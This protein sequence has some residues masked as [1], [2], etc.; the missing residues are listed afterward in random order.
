MEISIKGKHVDIGESLQS[1]AEDN[2]IT[3]VKKY[4]DNALDAKVIFSRESHLFLVDISVHVGRGMLVQGS[5]SLEDPYAAFDSALARISKQLRRYK[6]RLRSHRGSDKTQL[7][8]YSIIAPESE[9]EEVPEDAQPT[10]VAEMSHEISNLTVSEAVM[11]MDL[12]NAPVMM[13]RNSAHG[14]LNVVY[15]RNDGNVGWID[16][17]NAQ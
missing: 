16:P 15:R 6:R 12:A 1:H 9:I 3:N 11:R 5:A 2:L 10:I 13:F 14:E 8:Q 4:F 7:A 17:S